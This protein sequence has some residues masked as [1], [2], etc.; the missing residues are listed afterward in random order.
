[1]KGTAAVSAT[2][3]IELERK[4]DVETHVSV[5]DLSPFGT[6]VES[7]AITLRSVYF[8]TAGRDL[9]THR[10]TLRRR[11]GGADEGW[12]LKLPAGDARIERRVPL[13]DD[14]GDAE[15]VPADLLSPVLA[16]VRDRELVPIARLIT[17]RSVIRVLNEAGD[18]V[19]EFADDRVSATDLSTGILRIWREWEVEVVDSAADHTASL[20]A[21]ERA[22]LAAGASVSTSASK[23]GRATGGARHSAHPAPTA[24]LRSS[25][26]LEAGLAILAGHVNSLVRADAA[27][28]ADEPDGVHA[29]RIAVRRTRAVLAALRGILVRD[30]IDPVRDRLRV[31]GDVLGT[32]RDTEVRL[33]RAAGLLGD[34]DAYRDSDQG[35]SAEADA[36]HSSLRRRLL[37]DTQAELSV[38]HAEMVGYLSSEEYFRLL[39]DLEGLLTRPPLGDDAHEPAKEAFRAALR[40]AARRTNRRLTAARAEDFSDRAAAHA[41]RKAARRLRFIAEAAASPETRVL[42]KKA[43]RWGVAAHAVQDSLGDLRD[44][45]L[46]IDHLRLI[47]AESAEAGENTAA[48][49]ILEERERST[50]ETTLEAVRSASGDF[51]SARKR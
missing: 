48:Y 44:T 30:E 2:E 27:A 10:I 25:T 42:G 3:A 31:L 34:V 29:M 43:S 47:S 32:V 1:M 16:I 12:H 21:V 17:D 41:A 40:R 22:V 11:T 8:D 37:D 9:A 38:V 18:P 45:A 20:D 7:G 13:G 14:A 4:Y 23:V 5:P 15:S 19:L 35:D 6:V 51:R 39:D 28:R 36:G 26:A 50:G 24:D 33:S 46:F 49:D